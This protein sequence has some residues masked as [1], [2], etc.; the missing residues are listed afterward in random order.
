M[1]RTAAVV[2]EADVERV[3][4]CEVHEG[5]GLGLRQACGGVEHLREVAVEVCVSAVGALVLGFG[6]GGARVSRGWSTRCW[7]ARPPLTG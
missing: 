3:L 4:S 5:L 6:S 1:V 7:R 2:H